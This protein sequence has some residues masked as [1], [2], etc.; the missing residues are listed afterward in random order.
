M[1]L[2]T[3]SVFAVLATAAFGLLGAGLILGELVRLQ[4][5]YLCNLQRLLYIVVGFFALCGV[6][7]PRWRRSWSALVALA[8]GGGLSSAL[9]QSWMQYAPQQ[10]I[11]CGFGD[12][13]LA[14]QLINWLGVQWPALFMVTGFCTQKDWVFLGLSLANWSVLCF[15]ALLATALWLLWRRQAAG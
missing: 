10:V 14:E 12:P 7:W 3:R 13:T 11:E 8:A 15:S 9:Q 2:T 6:L 5:C 4:P 1:Y